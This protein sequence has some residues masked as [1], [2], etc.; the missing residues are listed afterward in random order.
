MVGVE[1][2]GL[3]EHRKVEVGRGQGR[4]L[5]IVVSGLEALVLGRLM[6]LVPVC[7]QVVVKLLQLEQA[8]LPCENVK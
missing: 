2:E 3:A 6:G 7:M 4:G 5:D 8:V 1:I